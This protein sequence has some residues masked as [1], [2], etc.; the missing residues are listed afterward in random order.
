ML[1]KTSKSVFTK[2]VKTLFFVILIIIQIPTLKAQN[3][4]LI[5]PFN[6]YSGGKDA[7]EKFFTANI[8]Y[9][10]EAV[11]NG[12]DGL[13]VFSFKI[14][15]NDKPYDIV[16][17]TNLGSGIE[18]T[19]ESVLRKT[20]GEWINCNDL[21]QDYI[22]TLKL[23]FSINSVYMPNPDEVDFSFNIDRENLH[24]LTDQELIDEINS[25]N[26][27]RKFKL[28]RKYIIKLINRYPYD[29]DYKRLLIAVEQRIKI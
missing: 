4:N 3:N 20:K 2:T 27:M 1:N 17:Q 24:I 21:P 9:P 18:E 28:S 22:M 23:T 13:L 29:E 15:C 16:Y 6:F 19:V 8:V 10:S 14:D 25:L 11:F 26:E 5:S 7:L 12:V